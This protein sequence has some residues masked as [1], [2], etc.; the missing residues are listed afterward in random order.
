MKLK[1]AI[2]KLSIKYHSN[3][4][5][6]SVLPGARGMLTFLMHVRFLIYFLFNTL[7]TKTRSLKKE[8]QVSE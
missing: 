1:I 5:D 3:N 7:S 2:A 6:I 4:K 8:G